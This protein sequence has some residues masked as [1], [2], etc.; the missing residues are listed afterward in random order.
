MN[1]VLQKTLN[2]DNHILLDIVDNSNSEK[3]QCKFWK[4]N[5]DSEFAAFCNPQI[6]IK[7]GFIKFL[8]CF[9]VFF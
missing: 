5:N 1:Y 3:L 2:T 4:T 8:V 9:F 7:C 6:S